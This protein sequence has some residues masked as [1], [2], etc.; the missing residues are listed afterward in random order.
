MRSGIRSYS[1]AEQHRLVL[2]VANKVGMAI[3]WS[4]EHE[5]RREAW[6]NKFKV[7]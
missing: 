1:F 2:F 3:A 6:K 4:E 7:D 5:E